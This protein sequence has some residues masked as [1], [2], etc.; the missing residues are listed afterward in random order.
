MGVVDAKRVKTILLFLLPGLCV[1]TALTILPIVQATFYS[2]F[3]WDGAGK[4]TFFGLANY[5]EIIFSK[6]FWNALK[7]NGIYLVFCCIGQ[8]GIAFVLSILLMGKELRLKGLFRTVLFI[9][10][11]LAPVVIGFVWLL[12][13]N[14]RFGMLNYVL[15]ALGL[16]ILAR[17]WLG[18]TKIVIFSLVVINI[19]QWIGYYVV[20]FL[21]GYQ[22]IPLEVLEAADIDGAVGIKKTRYVIIPLMMDTVRVC[23]MLCIAGT[24]KVFDQI[25]IMTKGG[26]GRASEV[27]T[28]YMYNNTFTAFRYGFGSAISIVILLVSFVL[29]MGSRRLLNEKGSY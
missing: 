28:M 18:D 23:L 14:V 13:Y 8:V 17:D 7:N 15:N 2:L 11:I 19:W 16:G 9:P 5:R 12:I 24:M 29:I 27:L 4:K 10:C 21:A 22:G 20:V 6:D 25:F 1:Y 3:N 26:P